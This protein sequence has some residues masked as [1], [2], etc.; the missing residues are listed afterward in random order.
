MGDP[1]W[2]HICQREKENEKAESFRDVGASSVHRD[3]SPFTDAASVPIVVVNDEEDDF[4][5]EEE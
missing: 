3:T 1:E 5:E 2:F 4:G